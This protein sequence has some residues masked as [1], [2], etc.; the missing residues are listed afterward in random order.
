MKH[1]HK[2]WGTALLGALASGLLGACDGEKGGTAPPAYTPLTHSVELTVNLDAGAPVALAADGERLAIAYSCLFEGTGDIFRL[3]LDD[4]DDDGRYEHF[5]TTEEYPNDNDLSVHYTR[6][7]H[8][9]YTSIGSY[10]ADNGSGGFPS[11]PGA[12]YFS[13]PRQL[14]F[15]PHSDRLFYSMGYSAVSQIASTVAPQDAQGEPFDE[16][17]NDYDASLAGYSNT[18]GRPPVWDYWYTKVRVGGDWRFTGGNHASV[19]PPMAGGVQWLAYADTLSLRYDHDGDGEIGEDPVGEIEVLA[20]GQSDFMPGYAG[21]DDD[22]DNTIDLDDQQVAAMLVTNP[23][24]YTYAWMLQNYVPAWDDDEDGLIDEDRLDL[25]D[26][27]GDGLFDEDP[28]DPGFDDDGDGLIDEDGINNFDDDQDGAIDEDPYVAI[29][30]DG[31]GLFD[32]DPLDR[33]DN[34]GDGLFDEDQPGDM[35]GD[36]YPG[37][38]GDEQLDGGP[39]PEDS[40]GDLLDPEVKQSD[41]RA[42]HKDDYDPVRDDD[43]DG[44]SDE[45]A[46][47]SRNGIWVVGI[48]ADGLPDAT[49]KPIPLTNDRGRQPFFNPTGS[50]LI[51]VQDGDIHRLTLAFAADTVTVAGSANLTNSAALEAY[52]AYADD[53]GR[54]V[55]SSSQYGSA[56]LFIREV[57][58]TVNR[59]TNDPG[60]E[61]YAR[62]TPDG[63]QLLFEGWLFPAG[64]RRVMITVDPLP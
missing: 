14:F 62:F 4:A 21:I 57:D 19:S 29:D 49:A 61:L 25:I 47:Y 36:G 45:D 17:V 6:S 40:L 60:Q 10:E 13:G 8:Q 23:A 18:A 63:Q 35:N 41:L 24:Q 43:E 52:P 56:D 32:E 31:D 64:T 16:I 5:A 38:P 30:N 28:K 7:D 22:G 37:V 48:G 53:G 1:G 42:R 46:D 58:G 54:I 20:G 15:D 9:Q 27:D 50:D 51:Y 39:G 34:D 2:L 59:V 26:N 55:Y 11:D 44:L 12:I 3:V 33:I